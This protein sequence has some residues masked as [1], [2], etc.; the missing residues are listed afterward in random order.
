M[1]V[2]TYEFAP[3]IGMTRQSLQNKEQGKTPWTLPELIKIADIMKANNI[4]EHLT[5]SKDGIKYDICIT[6]VIE[7]V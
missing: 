6:E 3:M 1:K 2:S 4:D 5:V 7:V